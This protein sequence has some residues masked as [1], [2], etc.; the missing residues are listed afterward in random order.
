MWIQWW[1]RPSLPA[2]QRAPEP[3]RE[4]GERPLGADTPPG[5]GSPG[6]VTGMFRLTRRRALVVV[7]LAGLGAHLLGPGPPAAVLDATHVDAALP[8]EQDLSGFIPYDG[9]T[10]SLSVPSDNDEGRSVLTGADLDEQCRTWRQEGDAWACRHVHGV[11]M[12]VL[13]LSE[14]VYF[15]VLSNVLAYDDGDAAEAGWDG[16]VADLRHEIPEDADFEERAADLG[17]ESL[18]FEGEGVTVLAIRIEAVVVDATIWDGS[19]QVSA[20]D[21]RDMVERWP[22]LQIS[23]IE[24]LLG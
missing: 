12:V 23:K 6:P 13:E 21:E 20:A 18:A 2:I 14:N 17:D 19:D 22:D 24:E 15:R 11:G 3:S 4:P 10:G 9:L 7:V 1:E 16:L 5:P 8:T